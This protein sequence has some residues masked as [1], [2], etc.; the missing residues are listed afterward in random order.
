MSHSSR[1]SCKVTR[2]LHFH[3][4]FIQNEEEKVKTFPGKFIVFLSRCH[5]EKVCVNTKV[6]FYLAQDGYRW[7]RRIFICKR[8][9]LFSYFF[10]QSN[11]ALS[12]NSFHF[13]FCLSLPSIIENATILSQYLHII[14]LFKNGKEAG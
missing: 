6:A 1:F 8:L 4:E 14:H 2:S 11:P 12:L 5:R 13:R 7:R 3:P 10:I 9:C